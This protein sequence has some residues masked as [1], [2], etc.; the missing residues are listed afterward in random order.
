ML[1]SNLPGHALL[2][3][4]VRRLNFDLFQATTGVAFL[5]IVL[6]TPA[7]P[8]WI[9]WSLPF[10]V[11]PS[12]AGAAI[13][14][15]GL[16][17]G[18]YVVSTFLSRNSVNQRARTIRCWPKFLGSWATTWLQFCIQRW[19]HRPGACDQIWKNPLAVTTFSDSVESH[20]L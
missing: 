20:L 2:G 13:L 17:S 3:M 11:L 10:L 18:A 8:G 5:L 1:S 19:C 12:G 6:M 14:L 4:A 15:V 7:S 9:V 16:F